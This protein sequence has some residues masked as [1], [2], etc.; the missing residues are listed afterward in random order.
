M[1]DPRTLRALFS[2]PGFTANARLRGVFGGRYARLVILSR[3]KKRPYVHAAAT[4]V[5]AVTI[6]APAVRAISRYP[7]ISDHINFSLA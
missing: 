7:D 6:N 1:N 2:M 5:E 4:A 3:R